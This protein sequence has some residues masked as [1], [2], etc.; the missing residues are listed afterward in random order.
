MS[1]YTSELHA[2]RVE[3]LDE[4]VPAGASIGMIVNPK[5]PDNGPQVQNA[6]AAAK[7]KGHARD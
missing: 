3:L 1:L 4:L 6:E 5:M 2:K 7:A